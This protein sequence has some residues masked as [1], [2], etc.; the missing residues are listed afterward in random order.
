MVG[1]DEQLP[2][3]IYATD[4]IWSKDYLTACNEKSFV[5]WMG[6]FLVRT[7]THRS[8]TAILFLSLSPWR[9]LVCPVSLSCKSHENVRSNRSLLRSAFHFWSSEW[10]GTW[11]CLIPFSSHLANTVLTTKQRFGKRS[12]SILDY[13]LLYVF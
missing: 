7:P 4:D 6:W 12:P 2:I 9:T 5:S 13:S 10:V 11:S 3:W 8:T 1:L